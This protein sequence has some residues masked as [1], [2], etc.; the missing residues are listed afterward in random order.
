MPVAL[1]RRQVERRPPVVVS[2]GHVDALQEHPLEGRHVPGHRGEQERHHAGPGVLEGVPPRVELVGLA[3][4]R[5]H[6]VEL[7]EVEAGDELLANTELRPRL[8]PQPSP[9]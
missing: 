4:D 2:S 6:L 8:S 1:S 5:L 9:D 7:V 3:L